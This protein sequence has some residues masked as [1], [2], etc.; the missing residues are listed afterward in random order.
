MAEQLIYVKTNIGGY[1]F[2]AIMEVEHQSDLKITSHPIQAGANVSD[3]AYVEPTVL[4][5]KVRM[6]DVMSDIVPGKFNTHY[7]RS[8]SAYNLLLELQASRVPISVR[9]RL[10]NYENM[11]IKSVIAPDDYTTLYGLDCTV[12]FQQIIVAQTK[13]VKVSKRM[14]TTGSTDNGVVA[15]TKPN[16]SVLKQLAESRS[17]AA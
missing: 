7:T 17:G 16:Q 12:T 15:V 1:F 10:K 3:H 14:Q 8:V 4:T 13:T 5:M 6:S 11:L 9:T 2:D